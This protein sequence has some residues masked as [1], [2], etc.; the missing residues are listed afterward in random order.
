MVEPTTFNWTAAGGALALC[1]TM[2][3][4]E[5]LLSS[6]LQP[7]LE[8]LHKPR[9]Y[10]PLWMWIV[11]AGLTYLLQGVIAYRLLSIPRNTLGMIALAVLAVLMAANVAYNLVLVRTRNP[12]LLYIGV[13]WFLP[14]LVVL[15]VL[16]VW[17]DWLAAIL[18]LLYVIWVI[19]YDLPIMRALWKMNDP[20]SDP[21]STQQK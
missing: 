7:W 10:L 5:S 13:I 19:G 18:N 17:V 12:R 15:Q 3:I 21:G 9:S 16:L 2:V 4:A 14:P 1:A 20:S 11:V 8:S 6:G